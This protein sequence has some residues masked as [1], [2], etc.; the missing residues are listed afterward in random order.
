MKNLNLG[1]IRSLKKL[2]DDYGPELLCGGAIVSLGFAI[3]SAFKASE[4]VVEINND[5]PKD[6]I[7]L[8]KESSPEEKKAIVE[9]RITRDIRYALAYKW[10]LMF[11]LG[12]VAMM[13]ASNRVSGS[14]IAGLTVALA[15]SEDKIKKLLPKIKEHIGEE[16]FNK[17][18]DDFRRDVLNEKIKNDE[19]VYE[20]VEIRTGEKPENYEVFFDSYM[21][22]LIE[23][24][25]SQVRDAIEAAKEYICRRCDYC[26]TYNKWRGF[27]GLDDC[28]AGKEVEWN[29][30][31]PFSVR[32]GE[33]QFGNETIK[34][35]EYENMPCV[36]RV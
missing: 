27:L 36:H 31:N 17:I 21:H 18:Q 22:S 3:G 35:I 15:A 10:V 9:R 32:I 13:I 33:L 29:P 34:T 11:G 20:P 8:S 4:K 14:K 1:V 24:P 26:L 19:P 2:V 16:E 7:T 25:E 5:F 30:L 28:P 6:E 12:S 23:V